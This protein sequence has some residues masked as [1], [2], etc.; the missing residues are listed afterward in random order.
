M[1]PEERELLNKGVS[2]V[3]DNNKMLRAMKRSQHFTSIMSGVYWV[4]IIGSAVAG[5][6]ILQP[7]VD[8]AAKMY[9]S[10]SAEIQNLKK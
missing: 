10:I 9:Q 2:L 7:Y 6:Y 3:E 1:S 4:I 8:Q 5:Y